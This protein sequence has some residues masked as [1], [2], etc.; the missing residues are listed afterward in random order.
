MIY[1]DHAATTPLAPEG[2]AAMRPWL[3][4]GGAHGN[5]ASTHAAGRTARAAVEQARAQ[6]AHGVGAQAEEIIWTSGATESNNLAIKGAAHFYKDKGKHVITSKIEH[7]ATIDSCRALEVE[8]YD[9]TYHEHDGGH[10]T[11]RD[12]VRE[13]IEWFLPK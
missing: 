13:A 9:V 11:P 4:P 2:W 8:G 3:E 10:G 12:I 1:L 5:A 6:V 7:K